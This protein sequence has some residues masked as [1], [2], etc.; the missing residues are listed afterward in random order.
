M[1]VTITDPNTIDGISPVALA[2]YLRARGWHRG[3]EM[4]GGLAQTWAWRVS[5]DGAAD[6]IVEVIVPDDRE[7]R[8]FRRRVRETLETLGEIERRSQLDILADIQCISSDVIRWRWIQASSEDGTIP[9]EQGHQFFALVRNQL[10]AAACSAVEPLQFFASRKPAPAVEFLRQARLG[11]S[12]R[13]SYVV[14]VHSPVPPAMPVSGLEDEPEPFERRVTVTLSKALHCLRRVATETV[15]GG[16]PFESTELSREGVSANLCESVAAMLAAG[17]VRRDIEVRFSFSG[18][19]PATGNPAVV[20]RFSSDLSPIIG[21]IGK[22]LRETATRDDF[23]LS[24]FVTDLS[25]GPTDQN[26]IAGVQGLVDEAYRRVEIEV[27]AADYDSIL[28]PAH[29][30]RQMIHCEGEL[31]KIKGKTYRL[32]NARGFRLLSSD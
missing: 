27:G 31:Q 5:D 11:Q 17:G 22:V 24:G 12:E 8:D 16:Q 7:M 18:S 10:L 6:E 13:G 9:L 3:P 14:T 19:R 2:S 28:T 15:S 26:G 4:T 30:D 20:T 1:N 21:E 32:M 25:R 29:R 23:E